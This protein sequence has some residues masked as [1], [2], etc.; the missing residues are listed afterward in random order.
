MKMKKFYLIILSVFIYLVDTNASAFQMVDANA[1]YFQSTSKI[2]LTD[3]LD[4]L[5]EEKNISIAYNPEDVQNIEVDR[6]VQITNIEVDLQRMLI[7][8]G[9]DFLKISEDSFIL[10]KSN[11]SS[12]INSF[13]QIQ[14]PIKVV[15]LII[16][17]ENGYPLIGVSVFGEKSGVGTSS[18]MEGRF[19]VELPYADVLVFS[20]VGYTSRS[21]SVKESSSL[22]I[23]LS[24]ES[25]TLDEVV[26]IG[27]GSQ[28]KSDLTGAVSSIGVKELK[29]LPTTGLEQA[30][31]GRSAGV[32]V[33]QNSGSPGG[34]MS[35]KIRGTASTLT[36]EPLYVIDGIPI[37]NDNAGT[38]ATFERD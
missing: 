1:D 13:K 22:N 9:L 15:G 33:T 36:A 21:E 24:E 7:P 37:I 23:R 14:E 30:I 8:F 5:T 19:E 34:A 35:I 32:Y 16:D 4:R 11:H 6:N 29:Q 25:E 3:F 31:Q 12:E 38:S 17:H 20:Y 18:D 10:K 27:Y 26:V 28:R 2:Q